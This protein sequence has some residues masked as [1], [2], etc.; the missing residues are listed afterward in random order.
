MLWDIRVCSECDFIF[1]L[2]VVIRVM[3]Y[4]NGFEMVKI[5][6]FDYLFIIGFIYVGF[7]KFY[8]KI[9]KIDREMDVYL[10]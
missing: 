3:V 6:S 9:V 7:C 1:L 4:R 8:D 2:F 5:V 10:C